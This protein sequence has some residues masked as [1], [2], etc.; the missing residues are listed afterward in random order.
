MSELK[1]YIITEEQKPIE[2]DP[3]WIQR[4]ASF[5]LED[6]HRVRTEFEKKEHDLEASE[7]HRVCYEVLKECDTQAQ[8]Q[9]GMAR[10][11]EISV[12]LDFKPNY[13]ARAQL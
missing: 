7:Y 9:W 4:L 3:H 6:V 12:V 13:S 11:N 5:V 1:D 2:R 10:R 8:T